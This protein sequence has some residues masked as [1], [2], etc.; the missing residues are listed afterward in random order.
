VTPF[1]TI[2]ALTMLSCR[3]AISLQIWVPSIE[4]DK[5]KHIEIT[6]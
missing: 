2:S 5:Q 6:C 1:S 4:I 3:L